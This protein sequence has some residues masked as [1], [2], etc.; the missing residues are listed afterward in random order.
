[1]ECAPPEVVCEV[2]V[3]EVG[4]EDDAI[5]I[6]AEESSPAPAT[7]PDAFDDALDDVLGE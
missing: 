6:P 4:E 3:E 5:E 1:M 2:L 7:E